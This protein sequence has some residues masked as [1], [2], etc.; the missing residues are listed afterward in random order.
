MTGTVSYVM[1]QGVATDRPA[2]ELTT[3]GKVDGAQ[4][5]PTPAIEA[6]W[7]STF[8]LRWWDHL[9]V[10]RQTSSPPAETAAGRARIRPTA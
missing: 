9:V 4:L 5:Q 2:D 7:I 10:D 1:S 8:N 3:A 6:L